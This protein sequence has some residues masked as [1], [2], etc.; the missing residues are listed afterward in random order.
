MCCP[1]EES[2]SLTIGRVVVDGAISEWITIISSMPQGSVLGPL[3]FILYAWEMIDLA[4]NRLYATADDSMAVVQE[5]CNHWCMI[6]NPNITKA[7][8]SRSMTMNWPMVTW[9]CLGFLSTLVPTLT[10]LAWSLTASSSSKTTCL[11]LFP[12]S[13][14]EL[15]FWGWWNV[16]LWTPVLL[17]CYCAFVL[18]ILEYSSR[19]WGQV[20]KVTFSFSST[21]CIQRIGA[22]IRV[23]C[24]C[25]IDVALV[26]W[27]CCTRLIRTR[28]TV[29]SVSLHQLQL[30]FDI[31]KLQ[32]QLI[33]WCLKYQCKEHPNLQGVSC[34]SWFECGMT[35]PMLCL[36]PECWMG[37]MVQSTIGCFPKLCF[38]LFSV[39]QVLVGLWKQFYKQLCFSHLG[40]CCWF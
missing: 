28:I 32:P 35:F 36:T 26:G 14:R 7:F 21:R 38:L 11:V 40:L 22:P 33:H 13:L 9:S 10:S 8:V 2:S 39:V 5:W 37:S 27:A 25:V 34:Q 30:E 23:S 3:L 1:F 18:P 17:H 12:V 29:C 19:V 24:C 6:L 15:V 31:L 4:E 16:Y 20:L